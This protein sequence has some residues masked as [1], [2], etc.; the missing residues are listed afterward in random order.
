MYISCLFSSQREMGY[1]REERI[2]G[3]E[4]GEDMCVREL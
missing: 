2:M 4:K 1:D 3:R